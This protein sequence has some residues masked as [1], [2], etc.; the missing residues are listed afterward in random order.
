LPIAVGSLGD[1][2]N[3]VSGPGVASL[4]ADAAHGRDCDQPAPAGTAPAIPGSWGHTQA[5]AVAAPERVR[6][7]IAR[8]DG[9]CPDERVVAEFGSTNDRG[10]GADRGTSSNKRLLVFLLP[11]DVAPPRR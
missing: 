6:R 1:N 8:D 7:D 11:R 2:G 9:P 5:M 10:V 3:V 4:G